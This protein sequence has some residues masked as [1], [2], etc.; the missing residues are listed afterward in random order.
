MHPG[1]QFYSTTR[2]AIGRRTPINVGFSKGLSARCRVLGEHPLETRPG[3]SPSHFGATP[4]FPGSLPAIH[5]WGMTRR[6]RA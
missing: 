1:P 4:A 2:V 6:T 5:T 3:L